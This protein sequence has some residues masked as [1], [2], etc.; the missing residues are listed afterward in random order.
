MKGVT[1]LEEVIPSASG[2]HVAPLCGERE[3]GRWQQQPQEKSRGQESCSGQ[4]A[5]LPCSRQGL[6]PHHPHVHSQMFEKVFTGV[7]LCAAAAVLSTELMV[8]LHPGSY[9]L[10]VFLLFVYLVESL[11]T[12]MSGY[13]AKLQVQGKKE[14]FA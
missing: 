4:E 1:S 12:L 14:E 3:G 13:Q 9:M 5:S 7:G 2:R 8:W 6:E 11:I 10:F